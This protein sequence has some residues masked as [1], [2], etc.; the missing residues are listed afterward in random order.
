MSCRVVI[1]TAGIGSRLE[2]FTRYLNKSLVSIANRPAIS[3]LIEQFSQHHEFVIPL[4]YKGELVKDFLE[5]AYPKHNFLFTYVNPFDGEGSGLGLSLLSCEH[6]LQEPFIFLSC[7]TL[8]KGNIPEPEYN[9]MGYAKKEDLSS[10]RTLDISNDMVSDINEKDNSKG[11]LMAYIGL[12]GIHDYKTFWDAMRNGKH[13]AIIQGE[14]Y[15][16]KSILNTEDI[17]AHQ[18]DWLDTGTLDNLKIARHEYSNINE[19]NILEKENESIWFVD[20]TVIK[21]SDDENFIKNRVKRAEELSGFVP[22]VYESRTN[23]YCYKKVE[24][25][26]LSEV[27]T[28][29][30]FECFLRL[31]KEL[32]LPKELKQTEKIEFK[33]N[34]LKFYRNKTSERLNLFYKNFD[35]KDNAEIINGEILPPLH[36]LLDCIDWND[37]SDGLAGRF[38]GDLHFENVIYSEVD[39]NFILLDWRQ[40]FAGQLSVGDIYYDLAK[41]LHGIIVNHGI[42]TKNQYSASWIDNIICYKLS[43]KQNLI[44]CEMKFYNWIEENNYNLKKVKIITALIYLNIA[45]LHHYPYSLLLYGL[46]KKMLNDN[47]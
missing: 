41:I 8:I 15:G 28:T 27:V 40:D 35:K 42:I 2:S 9:W 30:I 12:S 37:I 23:M 17:S 45:A 44:D 33:N 18:F 1:P 6:Y 20:K 19:P 16:L 22:E 14:A 32:W 29:E 26:V 4:G 31:C 3:H 10:Y 13:E 36:D 25:S 38:H 46:G 5:L 11:N 7:D 43:R 34:C 24:G 47:L 39:N 21:Y